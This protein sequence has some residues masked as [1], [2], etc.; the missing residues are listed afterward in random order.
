M[1]G[2]DVETK[3]RCHSWPAGLRGRQVTT[4]RPKDIHQEPLRRYPWQPPPRDPGVPRARGR[5][6]GAGRAGRLA[7]HRPAARHRPHRHHRARLPATAARHPG[8]G[9]RRGDRSGRLGAAGPAGAVHRPRPHH[10][11]RIAL[12][13]ALLSL[14]GPLSILATTE[15]NVLEL[16]LMHLAVAAVLIPSLAGTSPA[17]TRPTPARSARASRAAE[18]TNHQL[19]DAHDPDHTTPTQHA[20]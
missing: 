2:T 20:A 10:L 15:A 14:A 16:T 19:P 17:S 12:L 9:R 3:A 1:T 6:R 4:Q 13:V 5:R 11:D 7:D 18:R 8:H